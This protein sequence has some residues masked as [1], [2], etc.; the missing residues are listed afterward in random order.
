MGIGDWHFK[1]SYESEIPPKT[2]FSKMSKG[3]TDN[4][5][6]DDF[7][8][9]KI[10]LNDE[11]NKIFFSRRKELKNLIKKVNSMSNFNINNK[12]SKDCVNYSNNGSSNIERSLF[13]GN[14]NAHDDINLIMSQDVMEGYWD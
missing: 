12:N 5:Y 7:N 2:L 6:P 13:K 14:R 9:R 4:I 8:G 3:N 1:Y 11:R 10:N